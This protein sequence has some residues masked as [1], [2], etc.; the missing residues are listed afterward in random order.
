MKVTK[1]FCANCSRE[2]FENDDFICLGEYLAGVL[3]KQTW[4]HKKCWGEQMKPKRLAM[5]L[6]GRAN[7]LM[8]MAEGR[9][10]DGGKEEY[11]VQ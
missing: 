10:G 5:G 8:S 11:V 7:R 6:I 9:L 2:I 4:F 1:K 3:E